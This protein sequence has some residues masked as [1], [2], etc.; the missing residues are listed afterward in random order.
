MTT[1]SNKSEIGKINRINTSLNNK[2]YKEIFEKSKQKFIHETDNIENKNSKSTKSYLGSRNFEKYKIQL[3][4]ENINYNKFNNDINENNKENKSLNIGTGYKIIN[5][6]DNKIIFSPKIPKKN[7]IKNEKKILLNNIE[8][9][10]KNNIRYNQIDYKGINNGIF[11]DKYK[12]YRKDNYNRYKV[13][14][15]NENI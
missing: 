8:N 11:L 5:K 7:E 13:E 1:S 3:P 12:L 4:S 2:N 15:N 9:K 6:K 10:Y 14:N